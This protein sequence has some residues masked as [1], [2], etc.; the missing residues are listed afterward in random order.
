LSIKAWPQQQQQQQQQQ[1]HSPGTP[2]C[3]SSAAA[4]SLQQQRLQYVSKVEVSTPEMRLEHWAQLQRITNQLPALQ[5][6]RIH[7]RMAK[8]APL[9]Q[10]A[11]LLHVQQRCR[12]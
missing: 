10:R 4:S 6:I 12:A 11:S 2:A 3:L 5:H 9:A 8:G 1:V 7:S